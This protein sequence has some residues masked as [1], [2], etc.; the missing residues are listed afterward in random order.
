MRRLIVNEFLTIDGVAQAPGGAEEDRDGGFAHGGWHMPPAQDQRAQDWV[1]KSIRKMGALVLGGAP[2]RSSR[3]TG[4]RRH[5]R[6]RS[7][8]SP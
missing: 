6:S 2:M 1:M 3:P 8:P 5:R 7:S 4:R